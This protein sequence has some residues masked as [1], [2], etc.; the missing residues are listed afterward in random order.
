M[1]TSP[2]EYATLYSLTSLFAIV[3]VFSRSFQTTVARYVSKFSS[4]AEWGK[5]NYLWRLSLKQTLLVGFVF[6]GLAALFS[7]FL[8]HL[9]NLDSRWH[10]IL[11]LSALPLAFGMRANFGVLQ[12]L[13]R[14]LPL[15]FV[16]ILVELI[17]LVFAIILV[18]LGFGIDGALFP[19]VLSHGIIFVISLIVVRSIVGMQLD[20]FEAKGL[21]PMRVQPC[22]Q[23]LALRC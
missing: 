2:G 9:F 13:Q 22:W 11:L 20:N 5:I 19:V 21:F 10:L 7:S 3:A 16:G 1:L 23:L 12:G 18:L 6:F 17:K 4:E 14:F 8:C 15:S